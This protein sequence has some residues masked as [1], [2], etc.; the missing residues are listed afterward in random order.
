MRNNAILAASLLTAALAACG[1]TEP[2]PVVEQIIIREPGAPVVAA[3]PEAVEDSGEVDLVALG[4]EA[5]QV[6]AG[7]H[8]ADPG[9]PNMAGPNLN[10]VFGRKAGTAMDY[11][12][13]EALAS[14]D[15]IWGY[16]S[17]DR[18][19]ANPAGYVEGTSMV[20]GAVRNGDDRAAIVAYLAST[21]E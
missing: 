11:P 3:E 12:Y 9:G 21:G 6:C 4:E 13:S 8:N 14:S 2:E 10:G 15:I 5:F 7:C 18:F 17:L 16:A 20:A 19:L 1:S